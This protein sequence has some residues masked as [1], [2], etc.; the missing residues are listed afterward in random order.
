M[1]QELYEALVSLITVKEDITPS[2]AMDIVDEVLWKLA[3]VKAG[4]SREYETYG[5][6][7][8]DY[9]DLGETYCRLFIGYEP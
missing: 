2:E 9:L 6:V 3:D 1:E 7:L 4:E 8:R 5:E